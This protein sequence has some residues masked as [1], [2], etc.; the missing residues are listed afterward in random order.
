[1]RVT[2]G[3]LD[4]FAAA[5]ASAASTLDPRALGSATDQVEAALAASATASAMQA[6]GSRLGDHTQRWIDDLTGWGDEA[7]AAA[8]AYAARDA[9]T[10]SRFQA[11]AR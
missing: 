10:R 4:S 6:L 11:I 5:V 1:V 7:R 9:G 8:D 2:D 3:S